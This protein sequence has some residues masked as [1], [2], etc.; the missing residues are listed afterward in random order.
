MPGP[1]AAARERTGPPASTAR[2]SLRT[3]VLS[4]LALGLAARAVHYLAGRS[5]WLDE[6][7]IALN[8]ERRGIF[9]LVGSLDFNQAAPLGFL[10]LERLAVA[11][12]GASAAALRLWPFVAGVAALFLFAVLARRLS[13]P[14]PAVFALALFALSGSLVY[15]SAE[16]KQYAFD[17]A[18]AVALLW[19]GL[20]VR[21]SDRGATAPPAP[22]T[23]APIA[24]GTPA[25]PV[26]SAAAPAPTWSI[27]ALAGAVGVWFSHPLVF[28]LP[29][30][31]AYV[32]LSSGEADRR[33][34]PFVLVAGLWTASFVAAYLLTARGASGSP[35]M[36]RF[37]SEGFM[38]LAPT[39]AA[40]LR[41]FP[42]ALEGWL[43]NLID[44][45]ERAGL[46]RGLGVWSAA[47]LVT[48]GVVWGWLRRRRELVLI[49]AP[50]LLALG[51]SAARL[52]PFQGRL[53]LF[54]VPSTIVLAAWGLEAGLA[55]S[56][57]RRDGGAMAEG[58]RR[59]G[60]GSIAGVTLASAALGLIAAT[61]FALAQWLRAP[62]REELRPVLE[63]VAEAASPG[64]V[65]YL[66]SG[67]QHAALFYERTCAACRIEAATVVRGSFLAGRPEAIE[68]ELA[69]LPAAGRL[70][71]VFSHEWWGYGDA[72]RDALVAALT[73][74]AGPP[75]TYAAPGAEAFLFDLGAEGAAA[76]PPP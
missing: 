40:E 16:V 37:W 25:P 33:A 75:R 44:F 15:Y 26:G 58:A 34:R 72:E 70:W 23:S 27:L 38:P 2:P 35:L 29:G 28:V 64:D 52:Y 74:R 76:S 46:A 3:V 13:R 65:V 48:G 14:V 22:G 62:Y 59:A 31:L 6:S 5:L 56:A 19:V 71:A 47:V 68:A 20:A 69:R 63:R 9:E 24:R 7:M 12:L 50:L 18:A 73:A 11:G 43:A 32:W 42:A 30:V 10:W 41:W 55:A 49:G 1:T 17:V 54:L 8:L 60:V 36:A 45:E 21:P 57:T 67:A 66:H 51:A 4:L 39:T 53:I 61:G